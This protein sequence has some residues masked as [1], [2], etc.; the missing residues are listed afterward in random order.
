M[1]GC[2]VGLLPDDR[3]GP[4]PPTAALKIHEV[5][6]ITIKAGKS[7]FLTDDDDDNDEE[8]DDGSSS[9]FPIDMNCDQTYDSETFPND[10]LNHVYRGVCPKV[11]FNVV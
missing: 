6:S 2:T 8:E 4:A 11:C 3:N 10:S 9:G 5:Y 1:A 7:V